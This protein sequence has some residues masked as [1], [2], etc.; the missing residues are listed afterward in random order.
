M[1]AK[2]KPLETVQVEIPAPRVEVLAME[3]PPGRPE[4]RIIGEGAEAVPALVDAL[5]N[6]AKVL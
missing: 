2:K 4:G 1:A 3:F 5:R 6:E